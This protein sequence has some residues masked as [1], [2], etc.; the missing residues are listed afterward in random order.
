MSGALVTNFCMCLEPTPLG[1]PLLGSRSNPAAIAGTLAWLS[2]WLRDVRV[3]GAGGG[4]GAEIR[5]PD[6]GVVSSSSIVL[7][8]QTVGTG[9]GACPSIVSGSAC[10]A[11]A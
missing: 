10:R 7:T 5:R 4:T 2:G 6:Y 3:L 8:G 9:S 1:R 11:S